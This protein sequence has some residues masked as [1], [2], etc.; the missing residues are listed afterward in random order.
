[1]TT[2]QSVR[3]VQ[4]GDWHLDVSPSNA[5]RHTDHAFFMDWLLDYLEE[6][7]ID[8]FIHTGDIFDR[9]NIS[10]RSLRML[11]EFLNKASKIQSL[12]K[13]IMIS[14][15]HD[16][17]RFLEALYPLLQLASQMSFHMVTQFHRNEHWEKDFLFPFYDEHNKV[18]ALF[19]TLPYTP[20]VKLGGASHELSSKQLNTILQKEIYTHY[21]SLHTYG[22]QHFLSKDTPNV[23]FIAI[24]HL[25]C[26]EE[27]KIQR[28]ELEEI[29]PRTIYLGETLPPTIFPKTYDHVALGHFHYCRSM[30]EDRIWYSGTPV[31]TCRQELTQRH[32][33]DI[34]FTISDQTYN[35]KISPIP[36][37]EFRK[38]RFY[39]GTALEIIQQISEEFG[40]PEDNMDT[41]PPSSPEFP[42]NPRKGVTYC[43]VELQDE[44]SNSEF[45]KQIAT[46]YP[47]HR[48]VRLIRK[49]EDIASEEVEI[50]MT[51]LSALN[52]FSEIYKQEMKREPPEDL[53]RLFLEIK[54]SE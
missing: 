26:S 45:M 42:N 43:Y 9:H 34:H 21:E 38:T 40:I 14:G 27:P 28:R 15:N 39:R 25:S 18:I 17:N 4:T 10:S 19:S 16:S 12:K 29:A 33:L 53:V 11:A 44:I 51:D 36:I 8:V 47:F 3:I 23:P 22:T 7:R 35:K 41:A 1:M 48:I 37:P 31:T 50:Y 49:K 2:P 20:R 32:I 52:V 5:P 24:G 6:Q 30:D 54:D 13:I 46:K